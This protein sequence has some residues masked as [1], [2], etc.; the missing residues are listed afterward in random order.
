LIIIRILFPKITDI[1]MYE[2]SNPLVSTDW[3]L[4]D[5]FEAA[6]VVTDGDV[7]KEVVALGL[8]AQDDP[9]WTVQRINEA[10][11]G[12][13]KRAPGILKRDNDALIYIA[14]LKSIAQRTGSQLFAATRFDHDAEIFLLSA[15]CRQKFA[16]LDDSEV[17]TI[18]LATEDNGSSVTTDVFSGLR[19][20][21][22][23]APPQDLFGRTTD[24]QR[25]EQALAQSPVV[26]IDGVGGDGKTALAWHIA[27]QLIAHRRF[28]DF[29]WTTD[30]RHIITLDGRIVAIPTAGGDESF[31]AKV[32]IS[33]CRRFGWK[34][35]MGSRDEKL[36]NGCADKLRRGRYLVVVDNLETTDTADEIVRQ[37][38]DML[39]P[40]YRSEPVS[41][42]AL[43]TSRKQVLHAS[44]ASV[45]IIGMDAA[46]RV[47]YIRHLETLWQMNQ[48]PE[49]TC[50]QIAVQT[51]GNP[52]FIQLALRRYSLLSTNAVLDELS[53]VMKSDKAKI[54]SALFGNLLKMLNP[55][56][57]CFAQ[58]I[59]YEVTYAKEGVTIEG[60]KN[61]WDGYSSDLQNVMPTFDDALQ[62]LLSNR[63]LNN[64]QG[65]FF[66]MH[67]LIR[68]YLMS[69]EDC[70]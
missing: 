32:L 38:L 12:T 65:G 10:K 26:V 21:V 13:A 51:D 30:K 47:P 20:K 39:T 41:S 70:G 29:D 55:H 42:C 34:E 54:F 63:I 16:K 37:L 4:V 68:S 43:I 58:V 52:L 25:A 11:N 7:A 44:V 66:T 64:V 18:F 45:P 48:L 59:A 27:L 31:L 1:M 61:L 19:A 6:G 2:K 22:Q 62:E 56:I 28:T 57:V 33:V 15:A 9:A 50:Q 23:P 35:L 69:L 60:L 8:V 40:H 3:T 36:I 53:D 5:W 17:R 14:A 49:A 24:M 67:A 46:S